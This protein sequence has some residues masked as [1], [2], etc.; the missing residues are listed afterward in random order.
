[1][2]EHCYATGTFVAAEHLLRFTVVK[3]KYN[4]ILLFRQITI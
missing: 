1:M 4:K 3:E 2:I